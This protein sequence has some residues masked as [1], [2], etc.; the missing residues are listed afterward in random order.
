MEDVERFI[1]GQ[2]RYVGDIELPGTLH[3]SIIRSKYSRARLLKVEGGINARNLSAVIPDV[4]EGARGEGWRIKQPV[5]ASGQTNYLGQPVAAVYADNRYLAEDL[6]ASVEISYEPM[7]PVLDEREALNAKPIHPGLDSNVVTDQFIGRDFEAKEAEV[8]LEDTFKIGRIAT[9]P[10]EPRGIVVNYDGSRLNVWVSTQ[11]IFSIRSGLCATLGLQPSGVRVMQAD[12]GGAFGSK[13]AMY[14]EYAIA[15]FVSMKTR[16]PVK[17]L[18]SR[19]EHL[20]ASR[21]G[22]GASGSIKLFAKRDGTVI[23][24]KGE[25]IV[26]GGAYLDGLARFSP[27]FIGMQLTGPYAIRN[28]YVRAIS[29][30]TNSAPLGP[31]RGAG[32]PEAAFFR[33]RMMDLL[34][35][36]LKMDPAEVRIRNATDQVFTT[37]FGM[38]ISASR[39]FM[40][41][42]LEGLEYHRL[43]GYAEGRKGVGISYFVLV[44]ALMEGESCRLKVENGRVKA[45]LGGNSHGQAHHVFV[46]KLVSSTLEVP[47]GLVDVQPGDTD[48]ITSGVGV[49]GSRSAIVA[50]YATVLASQKLKDEVIKSKGRYTPEELLAG[51]YGAEVLNAKFDDPSLNSFGANLVTAEVDEL[52]EVTVRECRSYYDVGRALNREMVEGQ[53]AGGMAQGI[54]SVLYEGLVFSNDGAL[55]T[56]SIASAGVP[57]A[58]ALPHFTTGITEH[59]SGLPHGAKGVGEAPTIGVPPALVR[60][61]ERATGVRIHKLPVHPEDLVRPR[62]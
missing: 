17:W 29:V 60:A 24:L 44:P 21:P 61:M 26:N 1:R 48:M 38:K 19:S 58:R 39:Q 31:Y 34:A 30:A 54:S 51:H 45:W 18:E 40:V 47:A 14:P 27:M 15:A 22:R 32:R 35:D 8:V 20:M 62:R 5:F 36:E 23:G 56:D 50:G 59:P 12:T 10:I 52:G 25:I 41:E 53:I 16:R 37:P 9:D 3:L 11:S 6:M 2:G 13:S 33:E 57:P 28:G 4:G 49:W 42:A 43:A 7:Q 46:R 55:L